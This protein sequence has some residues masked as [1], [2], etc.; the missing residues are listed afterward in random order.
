MDNGLRSSD[1]DGTLQ[2]DQEDYNHLRIHTSYT[3]GPDNIQRQRST[4][5]ASPMSAAAQREQS[6]RLD[7]DLEMLRA[8]RVVS[9]A[10]N[11][12]NASMRSKSRL[13]RSRSRTA[14]EPVDD[15]DVNTTPL[16]EINKVYKPPAHPATNFAKFFKKVHNS[17]FLVRYFVYI[18]PLTLLFLIPLLFGL[19]LFKN[20]TVGGVTL[21]WFG[22]WLEI[23]WLTLWLARVSLLIT[24]EGYV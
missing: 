9:S 15:F 11:Q 8:E 1:E 19:L 17:S 6:R 4:R 24:T 20:T 16:H 3:A 5:T 10:E 18:T 13:G 22:I 2:D 21:F 14:G 7:D 12:D 23:V